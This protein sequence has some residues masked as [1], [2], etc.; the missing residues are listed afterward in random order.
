MTSSMTRV[1]KQTKDPNLLL[2]PK[3]NE[4]LL[5]HGGEKYTQKA[6]DAVWSALTTPG[7]NRTRSFSASSAGVCKRRQEFTYLGYPQNINMPKQQV[8]FTIGHWLHAQTQAMLLSANLIQEIE[9]PIELPQ[10]DAKGSMDGQGYVWWEPAN[11]AWK[12][13]EFILEVKTVGAHAWPK[14]AKAGKPSDDHLAQIHRYFAAT[15]IRLCSYLMVDKGNVGNDGII[16]YVVEAD[17][18]MLEAS[19]QELI[20]LKEA[21]DKQQLHPILPMCQM[22]QGDDYRY[23]PFSGK[24]GICLNTFEWKPY[25]G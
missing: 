4:Y 17:D 12:D 23:C 16:E 5:Q 8:I 6:M 3:I 19:F 14:K 24:E 9:V 20:D 7:R 10:Y 22:R 15:G 13:Q 11:P 18:E 1:L 2:L 21:A 25:S